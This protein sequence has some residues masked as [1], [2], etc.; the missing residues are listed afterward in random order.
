MLFEQ[1]RKE[2]WYEG[3][4]RVFACVKI[5]LLK[6]EMIDVLLSSCTSKVLGGL[7]KLVVKEPSLPLC[8]LLFAIELY[9]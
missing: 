4:P 1:I 5:F 2:Y 9:M 6:I 3:L 8:S 7:V